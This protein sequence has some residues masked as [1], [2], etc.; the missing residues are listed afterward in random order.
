MCSCSREQEKSVVLKTCPHAFCKKCIE[1]MNN[2]RNRKC[3]LCGIKF[4]K[5]DVHDIILS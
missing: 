1:E 3:P 2:S 5:S 4:G